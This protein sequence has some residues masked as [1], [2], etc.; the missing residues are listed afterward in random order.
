[1]TCGIY[2]II[3]PSGRFY[4]G[5]SKAI[6]R[7]FACHLRELRSGRHQ[8]KK[9]SSAFAKYG[10]DRMALQLLTTCKE[11]ELLIR[12]QE[13]IDLLSPAL[14]CSMIA[15]KVDWNEE[16]RAKL[17]SSKRGKFPSEEAR[18]RMRK[19]QTGK[20]RSAESIEKG[21]RKNVGQK[22]TDET[23]RLLSEKAKARPP[24]TKAHIENFIAAM[25]GKP[26]S[27]NRRAAHERKKE[28]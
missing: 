20:K 24:R 7:R 11:A 28:K 19:A 26:W 27:E 23:R 22:R 10:E 5:S 15:G 8:N 25:R 16:T 6:E 2:M 4:I 18:E 9:L 14:N 13:A 3:F 12:E 1:M 21:R 17:S